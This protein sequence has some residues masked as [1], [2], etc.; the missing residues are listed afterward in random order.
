MTPQNKLEQLEDFQDAIQSEEGLER[1]RAMQYLQGI[2]NQG[3]MGLPQV[4]QE[5]IVRKENG[6]QMSFNT[7]EDGIAN[8]EVGETFMYNGKIYFVDVSVDA[9]GNQTKIP[10]L[11]SSDQIDMLDHNIT[12]GLDRITK[13]QIDAGYFTPEEAYRHNNYLRD[14]ED[15]SGNKAQH[16]QFERRK[17]AEQGDLGGILRAG[18]GQIVNTAQGLA[19]LGR[20]GDNMLVHMNPE[21]V[22]GL[23]SLGTITY[24]P[25]TGLPEAWG[26]KSFFKPFKQAAK[27]IKK[28]A[29][30][31]AFRTLA[32]LAATIVAPY[33]A[34]K[35]APTWFLPGSLA[36]GL[37]LSQ[38]VAS[39]S[40]WAMGISTGLGS[41]FGA[42]V[43]GAKPKDALKA[44]AMSGVT[45]GGLRGLRNYRDTGSLWQ[46]PT[47]E[48]ALT[49][50]TSKSIPIET[51]TTFS[52]SAGYG[53]HNLYPKSIAQTAGIPAHSTVTYDKLGNPVSYTPDPTITEL[54][55]IDPN[56]QPPNLLERQWADLKASPIGQTVGQGMD[57]IAD[58][59][60]VTGGII[61]DYGTGTGLLEL[62]AMDAMTPD[63]RGDRER[64]KE[65][66]E[67]E[68]ELR[69][70]NY[71]LTRPL[72]DEE[73]GFNQTY[74][75][76]DP[77]G[78]EYNLTEDEILDI[79]YGR[80]ARPRLTPRYTF[81][82]TTYTKKGGLISLATGG[83]PEKDSTFNDL[84]DIVKD[85]PDTPDISTEVANRNMIVL[86]DPPWSLL[87]SNGLNPA[88]YMYM[89]TDQGTG[90]H[91]FKNIDTRKY[92]SFG[93]S[94]LKTGGT[95][96]KAHGGEFSGMVPGE[97]HGM[98]D[99]VYMPIKDKGKQVGTLAVSPTEYVVDSYT[100]SALGNGNPDAGAKVM[101]GVVESVR[102]K[103]YG[104]IKQPNEINGLEALRPMM[105][106]V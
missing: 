86:P 60:S 89:Y 72:T 90:K 102:K 79:A 30:S 47:Q 61:E 27:S 104:T 106:R 92:V 46:A 23:A 21:E 59:Q 69:R 34:A 42:L 48:P 100:M 16:E 95:I 31:K 53:Q 39:M 64:E 43:A 7:L 1:L 9:E 70:R 97:G 74:V 82:P 36:K 2:N 78:V 52:D 44:A 84:S 65:L 81:N 51:Q 105:E 40:P 83:M 67:A 71:E 87:S 6:G 33:L 55:T 22:A 62:A 32:P 28:V 96:E 35:F 98:E 15:L 91:Y 101:D 99:N 4:T 38:Q 14:L 37:T 12:G 73:S 94:N 88:D 80:R 13:E 19:D 58:P 76:V 93:S 25:I 57:Y 85:L 63:Y 54:P 77:S 10:A 68:E 26:I 66:R 56:Y 41:G 17:I 18:G 49:T 75:V 50:T 45:A 29:K 3:L 5:P 103:A 8:T 24:N 11:R 20:Y